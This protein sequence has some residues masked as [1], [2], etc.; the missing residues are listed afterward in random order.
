MYFCLYTEMVYTE[1]YVFLSTQRN[2]SL[3]TEM[4]VEVMYFCLD[5]EMD[6]SRVVGQCNLDRALQK[7]W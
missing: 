2:G 7:P 3:Y 6:C 4:V 1:N 5:R